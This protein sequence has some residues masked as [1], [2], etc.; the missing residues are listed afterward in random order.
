MCVECVPLGFLQLNTKLR[1]V[2]G[3]YSNNLCHCAFAIKRNLIFSHQAYATMQFS[4]DS[5]V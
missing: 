2:A 4:G 5:G 1:E 3:F